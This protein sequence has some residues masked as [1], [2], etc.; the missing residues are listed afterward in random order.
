MHIFCYPFQHFSGSVAVGGSFFRAVEPSKTILNSYEFDGDLL[1]AFHMTEQWHRDGAFLFRKQFV[2]VKQFDVTA[3]R[4]VCK[5]ESQA[6]KDFLENY[7]QFY[8][9]K[10]RRGS[11]REGLLQTSYFAQI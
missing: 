1:Q 4:I 10:H 8:L 9:I 6:L 3:K 2:F 7:S 11:Y 5:K